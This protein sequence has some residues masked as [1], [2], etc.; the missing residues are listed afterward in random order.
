LELRISDTS[1]IIGHTIGSTKFWYNTG[2]TIIGIK[3]NEHLFLSPGPDMIFQENDTILYVG[4][5]EN[6]SDKVN[7]FVN[8]HV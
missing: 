5:I 7:A 8:A 2:A 3:R 4:N 1:H 6:I